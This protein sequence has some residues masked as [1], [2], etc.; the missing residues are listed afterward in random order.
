MTSADPSTTAYL[1]TSSR[2]IASKLRIFEAISLHY[3]I[4]N[5]S[6]QLRTKGTFAS[7]AMTIALAAL[8]A[9]G[10]WSAKSLL[11]ALPLLKRSFVW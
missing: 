9:Y 3:Y 4:V 5:P 8:I 11:G 1:R 10:T 6:L 7:I 2:C